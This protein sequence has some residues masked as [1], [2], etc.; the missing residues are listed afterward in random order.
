[1]EFHSSITGLQ[2][3]E[4]VV[5]L[6]TFDGLHRGHQSLIRQVQVRA[7]ALQ[8]PS[9]L[10]TF[11][12]HPKEVLLK[13]RRVPVELLTTKEE[14]KHILQEEFDL[15]HGI[16]LPF[17]EQFS[18]VSATDF[19]E[20][21]LVSPLT[22]AEIIIGYDHR[23]GRG[24][25]GDASFLQRFEDT[26]SYK[27]TIVEAETINGDTVVS[28]SVIR[29]LLRDGKT[30]KAIEYLA[31]PYPVS[32]TVIHG[33][34]RGKELEFPTANIA[35]ATANKLLPKD[36]I[37]L[38]YTTGDSI[39]SYGLCSIGDRPTFEDGQ[40]AVEVF[41]MDP[42]EQSLYSQYLTI[43]F[44]HRLRDQKQFESGEALT[45]QMYRDKQQGEELI[46]TENPWSQYQEEIVT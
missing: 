34:G 33:A 45:R 28:S 20:Q 16:I 13:E 7:N 26:Y 37:Y 14:K 32:G 17:T 44:F 19:L 27:T 15:D 39:N 1:M 21:Y 5:T 31:R 25:E 24:R 9:V 12:P 43:H 8:V 35:P 22:P 10:I 46:A 6:G 4:S 3:T 30:M 41:L 36:G 18:Q 11:D 38:V 40:H 29:Y 2:L 42:P 23:F